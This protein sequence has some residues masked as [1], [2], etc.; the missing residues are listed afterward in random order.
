[1][2]PPVRSTEYTGCREPHIYTVIPHASYSVPTKCSPKM[3]AAYPHQIYSM[4]D[5]IGTVLI[6]NEVLHN[7]QNDYVPLQIGAIMVSSAC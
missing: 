5:V 4:I 7:M 1:M 6:K 3:A 2:A